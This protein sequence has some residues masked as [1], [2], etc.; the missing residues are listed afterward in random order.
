MGA[1][2]LFDPARARRSVLVIAAALVIE[3]LV[4]VAVSLLGRSALIDLGAGA[5]PTWT[6]L[7]LG[8]GA[9]A[10]LFAVVAFR[11]VQ[12]ERLIAEW[13]AALTRR[14]ARNIGEAAYQDLASV[15]MAGLREILMTDAPFLARFLTEACA[16]IATVLLWLLVLVALLTT[17]AA[18]LALAV[19]GVLAAFGLALGV[20]ILL[21]MRLTT[22]RFRRQAATSEDARDICEHERAI[23]M[24]QFGLTPAMLGQFQKSNGALI[25]ILLRQQKL[26]QMGRAVLI[27]LN[28]AGFL[29]IAFVGGVGVAAGNLAAADLFA[30]L[31]LAVQLFAS[32]NLLGELAGQFAET[33]TAVRR[34]G[35]YWE[36]TGET[37]GTQN[38]P[39]LE[40]IRF[41]QVR[42]GYPGK[43]P[44]IR[45]S[46]ARPA[47]R[48]DHDDRGHRRGQDN[49]GHARHRPD[50]SR[51]R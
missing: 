18:A 2:A 33:M 49:D 45:R 12:Q 20:L 47:A 17:K 50:P 11:R 46:D 39:A 48:A 25:D 24:R 44:V 4:F 7:P 6:L 42:F 23:A 1:A 14:L 30:A 10:L 16:A 34:L 3:L 36:P 8:L 31:F 37:I 32:L 15:P 35:L 19:A 26:A 28:G 29:V 40:T 21:H 43:P 38:A 41:D 9:A 22:T 51:Y 27:S 13:R 5:S